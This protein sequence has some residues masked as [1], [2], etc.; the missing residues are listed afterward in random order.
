MSATLAGQLA[1]EFAFV[2]VVLEG[3]AAVDEDYGN[4]IGELA[5]QLIVA[6]D[7]DGA[8]G[9]A[10]AALQFGERFLDDLAKMAAF[11]GINDHLP[12]VGHWSDST[13]SGSEFLDEVGAAF[14]DVGTAAFGCPAEQGFAILLSRVGLPGFARRD[15]RRRLSLRNFPLG[16]EF[17]HGRAERK[18]ASR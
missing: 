9:E 2:H 13:L 8:P 15:S 14:A 10:A 7:V 16:L 5:A 1:Q 6:I 3:F 11:A 18:A 17:P 12:G 4:L